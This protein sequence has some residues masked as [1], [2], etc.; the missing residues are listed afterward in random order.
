MYFVSI[1]AQNTENIL[2]LANKNVVKLKLVSWGIIR[3][4]YYLCILDWIYWCRLCSQFNIWTWYKFLFE[5]HVKSNTPTSFIRRR[6]GF[7]FSKVLYKILKLKNNTI[8]TLLEVDDKKKT[9]PSF[10]YCYHLWRYS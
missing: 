5:F 8:L 3:Y 9:H 10:Y 7:K 4:Y 2:I 6:I 1:A